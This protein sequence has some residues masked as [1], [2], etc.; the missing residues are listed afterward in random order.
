MISHVFVVLFV[1]VKVLFQVQLQTYVECQDIIIPMV[2]FTAAP[3]KK[4]GVDTVDICTFAILSSLAR[5]ILGK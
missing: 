4:G 3:W 5:T 1:K 2:S